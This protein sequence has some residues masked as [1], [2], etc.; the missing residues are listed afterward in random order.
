MV[1]SFPVITD[2]WNTVRRGNRKGATLYGYPTV[3]DTRKWRGARSARLSRKPFSVFDI[4]FQI[5]PRS[6]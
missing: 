6:G 4:L 5:C 3:G 2:E 1:I